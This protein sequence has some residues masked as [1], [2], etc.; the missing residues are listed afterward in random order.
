MSTLWCVLGLNTNP[1]FSST[2]PDPGFFIIKTDKENVYNIFR[3]IYFANC[4]M[5]DL[6][7]QVKTFTL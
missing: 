1:D 2:D 3:L 5:K 6:Q 7:A 4:Y